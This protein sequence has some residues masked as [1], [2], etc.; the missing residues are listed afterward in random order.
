MSQKKKNTSTNT[1][2]QNVDLSK[3]WIQK[4]TGFVLIT[5][6][7]VVLMIFIAAQMIIQNP[8]EW[9]KALLWGFLFGASIWVVFFGFN[10]FHSLFRSKQKQD[11]NK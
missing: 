7:S 9:P 4:K 5:G 10:W 2:N 6:L 1:N 3:P 11:D 8:Q